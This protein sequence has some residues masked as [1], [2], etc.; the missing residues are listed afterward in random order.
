MNAP[1]NT[2]PAQYDDIN[3]LIAEHLSG[4]NYQASGT[5]TIKKL[6]PASG[7]TMR[8]FSNIGD[9]IDSLMQQNGTKIASIIDEHEN[10]INTPG[11]PLLTKPTVKE[12]VHE[13][14]TDA[15]K[16]DELVKAFLNDPTVTGTTVN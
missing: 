14:D 5:G 16:R 2:N 4:D 6:H 1:G 9:L 13:I 3:Q 11:T 8:T 7:K 10:L 15:A 12:I